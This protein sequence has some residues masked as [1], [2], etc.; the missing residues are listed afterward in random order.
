VVEGAVL[1]RQDGGDW[2]IV[3]TGQSYYI[4]AGVVHETKCMG[5]HTARTYNGYILEKASR[6]PPRR[7]D[8]HAF[9]CCAFRSRKA[10]E[11][12][13]PRSCNGE[14]TMT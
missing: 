12:N 1:T 10:L 2:K 14:T 5:D 9:F 7:H 4:P 3:Q 13:A 11:L 6:A 8:V